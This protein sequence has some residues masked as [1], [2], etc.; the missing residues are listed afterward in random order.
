MYIRIHIHKNVYIFIHIAADA[1]TLH[2]APR[3]SKIRDMYACIYVC[4][5]TGQLSQIS[6]HVAAGTAAVQSALGS[7]A[8][9]QVLSNGSHTGISDVTYRGSAAR[10]WM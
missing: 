9:A 10:V 4:I 7:K 3:F 6:H 2:S 8:H 5:Y 1:A